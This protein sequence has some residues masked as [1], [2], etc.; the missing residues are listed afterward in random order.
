MSLMPL[1]ADIHRKIELCLDQGITAFDQAD[2]YAG[3]T[4]ESLL[5]ATLKIA[6][7]L[8]EKMTILLSVMLSRRLVSSRKKG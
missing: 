8:G 7:M 1:C 5:G 6:P 3:Y 4:G 2:I